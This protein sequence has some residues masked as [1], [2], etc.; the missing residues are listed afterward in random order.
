MK[1]FVF[2]VAFV[3]L[4]SASLIADNVNKLSKAH[5]EFAFSLYSQLDTSEQNL[6]FSPYSVAS[7]LEMVYFGARGETAL[8]MEKSLKLDMDRK[9]L[10]K[11]SFALA[12]SLQ[13]KRKEEN[14]YQL[15]NANALW[16]DQRTFLLAD[17]RYAI[18]E[19]FKAKL[20]IV[21]F[22]QTTNALAT[23]NSWVSE[24]TQNQIPALLND[25][26]IDA[27]TRLILTNAVYFQGVW[28]HPFDSKQTKK[29][30]F[31]P[32]PENTTS[33]MMMSQTLNAPYYEN[34]M[35]QAIALP[36]IGTTNS[37]GRLA[38]IIFMPKSAD[39]FSS[40]L[41]EISNSYA[42]WLS[43]FS[44]QR[45]DFKLPKFSLNNRYDLNVALQELGIHD[46]FESDANFIGI[47]GMR[48]LYL[49]KVVH[50]T[51]F[52]LDEN[53]VTAAA[54]TAA[55]MSMKSSGAPQ[56]PPIEM[57]VDHPFL[58]F[59]VD[60]NSQEMLFMGKMIQ[61]SIIEK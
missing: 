11:A 40:M 61:P 24:Q 43:S 45:I 7:C 49:N 18:E 33:V 8:Q 6:V 58:F 17:F 1:S 9:S 22:S 60:L 52:D 57:N 42:D 23:I 34:D 15:N 13:L 16:V 37:G 56:E 5:R 10:P 55:S 59:I 47:D 20:G 12:Q 3:C 26:D 44:Q 21:N 35:I 54:A 36:F 29:A 38:L 4:A 19:Q 28:S 31:Y 25:K 48:D 50:Q 32:D 51:F 41:Q 46:A 2:S 53:G 27:L 30:F 14:A 39:N